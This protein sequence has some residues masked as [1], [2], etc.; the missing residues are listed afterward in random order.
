MTLVLVRFW[1]PVGKPRDLQQEHKEFA[2]G[3]KFKEIETPHPHGTMDVI[4]SRMEQDAGSPIHID[5]DRCCHGGAEHQP[6]KPV[7][8]RSHRD[9]QQDETADSKQNRAV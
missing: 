5:E 4:G 8:F 7:F 3:G 9:E 1:R 6:H 2:E